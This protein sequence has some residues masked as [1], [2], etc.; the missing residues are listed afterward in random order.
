M[1]VS[2]AHRF[3]FVRGR[4][5]A[6][7]SIEMALSTICGPDDIVPPMI[8]VDERRRQDMN[9]RC[10]N[11]SDFP[12]FE[13]AYRTLVRET[14]FDHLHRLAPPASRYS[15]H[16]S[17]AAIM[18]EQGGALDGFRVVVAQRCPYARVLSALNM[19]NSF[20]A[21][22]RG[23]EMRDD[24]TTL[25]ERFDR[26]L[27]S[28]TVHALRNIDLYRDLDGALTATVI[29]YEQ[30]QAGLDGFL[31]EI[32][33]MG[34][35]AVPHAKKGLMANGLDPAALLR[36]DQIATIGTLFADEFEMFGYPRL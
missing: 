21:Y 35:I 10:G 34:R 25:P 28:G 29:R 13:A 4:K 9:G 14:P 31:D 17:L 33:Y 3:I 19:M 22:R 1:I 23:G 5:V 20:D 30:L 15:A 11:Y 2:F 12:V 27:A 26:A 36:P 16:M 6:G 8:A 32:G 7:T 24:M 18:R